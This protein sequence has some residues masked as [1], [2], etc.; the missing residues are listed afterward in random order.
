MSSGIEG[1]AGILDASGREARRSDHGGRQ[2]GRIP[3][4]RAD[5]GEDGV[6]RDPHGSGRGGERRGGLAT[7][8]TAVTQTFLQAGA[9]VVADSTPERE[10]RECLAKA[11]VLFT[12]LDEAERMAG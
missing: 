8:V 12:A 10:D 1:K 7:G 9:G 4:S 2:G 5:P 11:Q 3:E 6:E